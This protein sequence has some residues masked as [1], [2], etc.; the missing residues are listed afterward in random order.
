[1]PRRTS[2]AFYSAMALVMLRCRVGLA[3][4]GKRRLI[5]RTPVA[6]VDE[7]R[8]PHSELTD[9]AVQFVGMLP[10]FAVE[11]TVVP[12]MNQMDVFPLVSRQR[13]SVVPLPS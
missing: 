1:L 6:D 3:P 12:F 2:G 9:C 10:T 11:D 13:M 4:T 7:F 5:T 8:L